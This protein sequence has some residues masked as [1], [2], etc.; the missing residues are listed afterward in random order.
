MYA[1]V[2][3]THQRSRKNSK[4][5]PHPAQ[6]LGAMCPAVHAVGQDADVPTFAVPPE[7][8]P[9][10]VTQ[11]MRDQRSNTP[12][13]AGLG[14]LDHPRD[15]SG[16]T[17][18]ERCQAEARHHDVGDLQEA[19]SQEPVLDL[20]R[21]VTLDSIKAAA[22]QRD[23]Y[24]IYHGPAAILFTHAALLWPV[25]SCPTLDIWSDVT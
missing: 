25:I 5:M 23:M 7:T 1:H 6:K 4:V 3:S 12:D 19:R 10:R 8:H 14:D 11:R 17:A 15:Q 22:H 13:S 20:Q 18:G 2:V 9:A 24:A 21:A 16:A